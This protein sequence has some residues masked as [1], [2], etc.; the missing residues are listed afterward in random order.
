VLSHGFLCTCE[1]STYKLDIMY[2]NDTVYLWLG[3]KAYGGWTLGNVDAKALH[4]QPDHIAGSA[5]F[6]VN[7][8]ESVYIPFRFVCGQAQYGG[9]FT[10]KVT[11]PKGQVIVGNNIDAG[12]YVVR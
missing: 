12:P 2:A 8:T 1:A 5:S 9:G 11:T 7:S 6:E 3:A 4:N 10:S